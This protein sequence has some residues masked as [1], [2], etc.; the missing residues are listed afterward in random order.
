MELLFYKIL[1]FN[2][3]T[4]N[5]PSNGQV[6]QQ[7]NGIGSFATYSCSEGYEIQGANRRICTNTGMWSGSNP[8]CVHTGKIYLD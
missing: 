8:R 4:L 3:G 6:L 2:C 5:N 7:G 1:V